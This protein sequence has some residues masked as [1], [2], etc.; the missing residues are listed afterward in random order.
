[1][2]N[3]NDEDVLPKLIEIPENTLGFINNQ[4]FNPLQNP[5]KFEDLAIEL[6]TKCTHLQTQ[7][8]N[9]H[10]TLGS[11][12]VSWTSRS[13]GAKSSLEIFT[14]SLENLTSYLPTDF[15]TKLDNVHRA[16]KAVNN[17]EELLLNVLKDH[18]QWRNLLK[19]V[20]ARVDRTLGVL[21][22]QV[23]ADH[24]SLLASLGWPPKTLASN[25]QDG[26]A[27][28]IPNPLILMQGEKNRAIPKAF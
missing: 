23:I 18:P 14:L 20:D 9:L 5:S 26:E 8:Q 6:N 25:T 7:L 28:G 24:R 3:L 12:L 19:A 2:D 22:P 10:T 17:I 11:L 15:Y 1:M 13:I 4:P 16:V 27:T 21:R